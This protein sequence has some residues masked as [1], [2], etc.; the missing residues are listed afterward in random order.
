MADDLYDPWH[1]GALWPVLGALLVVAVLGWF[2]YLFWSTRAVPA[3]AQSAPMHGRSLAE[4][5]QAHLAELHA[6][7]V[8]H[9][10]GRLPER[11]AYQRLSAIVRTFA[12]AAS[13]VPA[14]TMSLADLK[15]HHP[16]VLPAAIEQLYPV[17]FSAP[18]AGVDATDGRGGAA[19]VPGAV[20][21][22]AGLVGGWR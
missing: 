1:Y 9:A 22:A 4:L 20:A 8:E 13:G 7:G 21:L 15:R 6:V 19:D 5:K 18:E 10:A 17:E 11:D 16:G 14:H 3:T 12:F 2:G